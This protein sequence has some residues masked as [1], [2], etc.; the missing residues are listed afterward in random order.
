MV[1]FATGDGIL[2]SNMY[3]FNYSSA[4]LSTAWQ[5][6]STARPSTR[7]ALAN[8]CA[9]SRADYNGMDRG[10]MALAAAGP[11]LACG[12]QDGRV[13]ILLTTSS[14]APRNPYKLAWQHSSAVKQLAFLPVASQA[15]RCEERDPEHLGGNIVGTKLSKVVAVGGSQGL[16]C[17]PSDTAQGHRL[18]GAGVEGSAGAIDLLSLTSDG[19]IF[20][21]TLQDM[22]TLFR[23]GIQNVRAPLS[24][25]TC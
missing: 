24:F 3:K 2:R 15:C 4:K 9:E 20:W 25:S 16:S 7:P 5:K 6:F 11:I 13:G 22:S 12:Y 18:Q 14:T 8:C 19:Q 21:G 17:S 23:I 10:L 1:Y